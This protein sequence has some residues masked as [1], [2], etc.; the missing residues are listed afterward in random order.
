SGINRMISGFL[1]KVFKDPSL[2]FDLGASL[3]SSSSIFGSDGSSLQANS[4]RLDRSRVNFKVGKS[5]LKNNVTV[6]FGGDFD[7]NLGASSSVQSG[8]FQWLP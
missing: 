2:K 7:F 1:Y 5:F 6:T 3:Y 8:N 4:N